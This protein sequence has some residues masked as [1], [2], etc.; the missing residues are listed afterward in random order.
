M[1]TPPELALAYRRSAIFVSVPESD[2]TSV[3][4]LESMGAGC[5]PVLSDL[6]ANREWVHDGVDGLLVDDL[7]RLDASLLH[8]MAWC[9][10]GRWEREGRPLNEQRVAKQAMFPD[11]IR[12]FV[13][14]YERL[15]GIQ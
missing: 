11:N 2:G 6:P 14:L 8:A 12:Q 15:A 10:S 5:L 7:D 9:E 1:L 4:L 3:S 13:A